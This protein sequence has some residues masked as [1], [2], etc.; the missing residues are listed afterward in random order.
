MADGWDENTFVEYPQND[1]VPEYSGE[2]A[3]NDTGHAEISCGGH[4]GI[5]QTTCSSQ[6][7]NL[8]KKGG[9]LGGYFFIIDRDVYRNI[10]TGNADSY[11]SSQND[12][13]LIK[14]DAGG[15][16]QWSQTFGGS[17]GD[18]GESVQQTSEGGYI[19]AEGPPEDVAKVKGSHTGKFLK[20]MLGKN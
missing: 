2:Y 7:R 19:I 12:V 6:G 9:T 17:G 1:P 13:Y 4:S 8:T 20:E 18:Y 16:E 14:T 11:S 5:S 15:N 3:V 10:I